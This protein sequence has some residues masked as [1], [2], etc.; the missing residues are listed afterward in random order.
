MERNSII[1]YNP[2]NTE[3]S[4]HK[5]V[6]FFHIVT[7]YQG[8]LFK[9]CTIFMSQNKEALEIQKESVLWYPREAVR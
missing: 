6:S 5:L 8:E 4:V 7:K 1:L 2:P 3:A 9:D